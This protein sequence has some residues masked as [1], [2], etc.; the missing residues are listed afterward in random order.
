[1]AISVIQ[2][3]ADLH[4]GLILAPERYD[5]RRRIDDDQGEFVG[6][7][8][9]FFSLMRA[10]ITASSDIS[11][12]LVVLDTSDADEGIIAA[13]K[14]SIVVSSLGSSKK[15]LGRG[16]VIISRLRPYLRQ[17]GFLDEG[18]FAAKRPPLYVAST[19]FFVLR[20]KGE[21]SGA[22]LVPLLLSKLVQAALA[23]AQEG[24]HH[25]RFGEEIL[26]KIPVPRVLWQRRSQTSTQ[27]SQAISDFRKSERTMLRAIISVEGLVADP[28]GA[29]SELRFSSDAADM[30]CDGTLNSAGPKVLTKSRGRP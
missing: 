16:D 18:L 15:V 28:S 19:E 22:F 27:V 23:A 17:V 13:R 4:D 30:A 10:T 24:G 26:L 2:T 6:S 20:F 14:A 5:P 8:G 21:G 9:D 25:P 29:Q 12:P 1:M 3:L 11:S 7:V